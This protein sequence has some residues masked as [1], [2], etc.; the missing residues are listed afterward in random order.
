M[1]IPSKGQRSKARSRQN[2]FHFGHRPKRSGWLGR[3]RCSPPNCLRDSRKR[4]FHRL[5]GIFRLINGL[6]GDW[7]WALAIWQKH[8]LAEHSTLAQHF[9]RVA[10]LFERQPLRDEKIDL[11]SDQQLLQQ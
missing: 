7:D 10:R 11:T 6:I 9:V 4:Y 5:C 2:N 1:T 8:Y 3:G